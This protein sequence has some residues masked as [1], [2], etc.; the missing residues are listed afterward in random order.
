MY[1]VFLGMFSM[2]NYFFINTILPDEYFPVATAE[3]N[4]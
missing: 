4:V 1:G 2:A 3:D